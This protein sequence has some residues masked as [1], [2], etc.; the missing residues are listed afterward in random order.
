MYMIV[1]ATS[2]RYLSPSNITLYHSKISKDVTKCCTSLWE[3]LVNGGDAEFFV[4]SILPS[5][6]YAYDYFDESIFNNAL[7]IEERIEKVVS[8]S[9]TMN[10]LDNL[11]E[12]TIGEDKEF[13]LE[14]IYLDVDKVDSTL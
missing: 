6:A 10:Q 11:L 13:V 5:V 3:K 1:L 7:P 12:Y 8:T 14:T 9:L 4:E 2:D